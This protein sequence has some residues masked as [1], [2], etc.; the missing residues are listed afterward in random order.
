MRF[1]SDTARDRFTSLVLDNVHPRD[2]VY[3]LAEILDE[4]MKALTNGRMW[5]AAHMRRGDCMYQLYIYI[6]SS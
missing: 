2:I 6:Y 5:M 4:R 1:T 3:Q